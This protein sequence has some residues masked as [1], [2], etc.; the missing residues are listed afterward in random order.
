MKNFHLNP[1]DAILAAKDLKSK[2]NI[3]MHLETFQLTDEG[4]DVP[5]I[6]L[7]RLIKEK[8]PE[9]PFLILKNG[10]TF[11]QIIP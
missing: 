2:M 7:N 1:E 10:E 3:G 4:I 9:V 5:R 6:E 8:Y 11:N